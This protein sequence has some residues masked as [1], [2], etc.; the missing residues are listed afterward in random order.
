MASW[1]NLVASN[2]T[3]IPNSLKSK[4]QTKSQ[5]KLK[6]QTQSELRLNEL[7]IR[8]RRFICIDSYPIESYS[9]IKSINGVIML[10]RDKDVLSSR[11]DLLTLLSFTPEVLDHIDSKFFTEDFIIE[12]YK[13][14]GLEINKKRKIP[15]SIYRN[16]VFMKS[17]YRITHKYYD[18][19]YLYDNKRIEEDDIIFILHNS[20]SLRNELKLHYDST[21][22]SNSEKI[23]IKNIL[24][25]IE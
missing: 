2:N 3:K 15:I 11:E 24:D 21:F 25:L 18:F 16:S 1:A 10:T 17:L 23:K 19:M 9:L 13:I 20:E 7:P 22:D 4:S 14:V 8:L 6:S 5:T 12:C